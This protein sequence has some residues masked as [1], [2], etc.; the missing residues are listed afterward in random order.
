[1]SGYTH[2]MLGEAIPERAL[3]LDSGDMSGRMWDWTLARWSAAYRVEQ[4]AGLVS[5]RDKR[6][7][8]LGAVCKCG[9]MATYVDADESVCDT[10]Y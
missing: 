7:P 3:N 5:M 8:I 4:R 10:C 9:A 6:D 2:P 1:M